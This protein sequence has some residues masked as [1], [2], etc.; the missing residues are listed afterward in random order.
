MLGMGGE[1][2][3][4]RETTVKTG[5]MEGGRRY[6]SSGMTNTASIYKCNS[7]K[8]IKNNNSNQHFRILSTFLAHKQDSYASIY[9]QFTG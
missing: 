8:A 4:D 5:E 7:I 2:L 6:M 9:V 3:Q 1:P